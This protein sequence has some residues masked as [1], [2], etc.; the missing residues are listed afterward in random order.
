[1]FRCV[2]TGVSKLNTRGDVP[3]TPATWTIASC[4]PAPPF[5]RQTKE[6]S[7]IHC[8]AEHGYPPKCAVGFS[9]LVPKFEPSIVMLKESELGAFVEV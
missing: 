2:T 3:N 4:E 7:L 6:L 8:V 1:M 5:D 9:F